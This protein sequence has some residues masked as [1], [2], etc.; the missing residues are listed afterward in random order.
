MGNGEEEEVL[1]CE[2]CAVPLPSG[3]VGEWSRVGGRRGK[4]KGGRGGAAAACTIFLWWSCGGGGEG[5]EPARRNGRVVGDNAARTQR[6]EIWAGRFTSSLLQFLFVQDTLRALH[7]PR[8]RCPRRV[9]AGVFPPS[10][11]LLPTTIVGGGDERSRSGRQ[12]SLADA[13]P[14]FRHD[15]HHRFAA[16][17][18]FVRSHAPPPESSLSP[19]PRAWC[20]GGTSN[21][22]VFSFR[23]SAAVARCAG[24]F[25]FLDCSTNGC[26]FDE[27]RLDIYE[28]WYV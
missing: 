25:L 15:A 14:R 3:K 9:L 7:F 2:L 20:C 26:G 13:R 17:A 19:V 27:F 1:S 24:N 6:Q 5:E 21:V 12:P 22:Q 16:G 10:L 18:A 11:L 23:L 8:L 4:K 28:V